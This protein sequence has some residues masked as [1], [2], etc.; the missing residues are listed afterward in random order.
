MSKILSNTKDSI[1]INF[2]FKNNPEIDYNLIAEAF[3]LCKNKE[4]ALLMVKLLLTLRLSSKSIL[5]AILLDVNSSIVKQR[6]GEEILELITQAKKFTNLYIPA[7]IKKNLEESVVTMLI[8]YA[9]DVR[10]MFL[11][12]AYVIYLL[13]FEKEYFSKKEIK[14]ILRFMPPL[15]LRLNLW[16]LKMEIENLCLQNLAPSKYF[17]IEKKL[18]KLKQE[19]NVYMN[20]CLEILQNEFKKNAIPIKITGRIKHIYSIYKKIEL[21]KLTFEEIYDLIALR[22]IVNNKEDCYKTLGIIHNLWNP[23]FERIKDYIAVPKPNNYQSLH[24]T[25]RGP[26]N[27]YIE[28][29]IRTEKMDYEASYGIAAHWTYSK[30]KRSEIQKNKQPYWI[31]SL[32]NLQQNQGGAK[33]QDLRITFYKENVSVFTEDGDVISLSKGSNVID[34]AFSI[35]EKSEFKINKCKINFKEKVLNTVLKNG[36]LVEIKYSQK[37]A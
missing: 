11:A 21:K 27:H 18:E 25:V 37:N 24:T 8:A 2:L 17:S 14:N 29:Q 1:D 19:R 36:D 16:R 7:N 20:Y 4:R 23:H 12:I 6:F 26:E 35:N 15:C 32:L 3:D 28:I 22:I 31:K 30:N 9:G 33:L 34:L 10:V 13:Q 5:A